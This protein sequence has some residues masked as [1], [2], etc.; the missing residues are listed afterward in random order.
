MTAN[1]LDLGLQLFIGGAWTTAPTF[2]EEGWTSRIGP[3]LEAGLQP[4]LFTCTIN[5]DTLAW[6]PSYKPGSNYGKFGRYTPTRAQIS[7]TTF[8]NGEA[9]SYSPERTKDHSPGAHRGRS[10]V[11][12]AFQG[13]QGRLN[14]WDDPLDSPMRRRNLSYGSDIRGYYPL[15]ETSNATNLTNLAAGGT[16]GTYSGT[17]SFGAEQSSGGSLP[18]V[19]IGSDGRLSG[20]F[21]TSTASGWQ[22][23]WTTKFD[24]APSSA[25]YET[26]MAWTDSL[27][28]EWHWDLNDTSFR[29]LVTDAGGTVLTN[30]FAL[31]GTLSVTQ[32]PI[33]FRIKVT[34]SAGTLQYEPAWHVQDNTFNTGFTSTFTAASTAS[35]R[36]WLVA[37]NAW[38]DG[39]AYGHVLTVDDSALDLLSVE[40]ISAFD[41]YYGETAG[42]RFARLMDENGLS[43]TILGTS[44][45]SALMGRQQPLK[46]LELLDEC[47]RTDD[48]LIYDDPD[49]ADELIFRLYGD[50]VNQTPALALTYGV[51]LADPFT[52]R[53]DDVGAVNDLT[54]TNWDGEETN[55]TVDTGPRSTLA[56]PNGDGRTRGSLAVSVYD[57]DDLDQ[58]GN[59]EVRNATLD[60]PRY[61]SVTF[62]LLRF[63]SYRTA[64]DAIRP[65]DIVTVDSAEV[66]QVLI[67]VLT[68]ERAGSKGVAETVTL[69]GTPGDLWQHGTYDSGRK[70]SSSKTVVLGGITSS[71]TSIVFRTQ[72]NTD[73]PGWSATNEPYNVECVE[74]GEVFTVTSM[75]AAAIGGT[76]D[77]EQTAT[78]TRGTNGFSKAI[79][80][81]Y[82][83]KIAASSRARWGKGRKA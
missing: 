12:F 74:T 78:I 82:H 9:S 72:I 66:D 25:T 43:Y 13:L 62:S 22:L 3:D 44:S 41:G 31:Y 54:V 17:V 36:S 50:L 32:Q 4:N 64:V 76:G 35:P 40:A 19:T 28:R 23:T 34:V 60:R 18:N 14:R 37:G 83:L 55:V 33:R 30:V 20:T 53:I 73:S 39:A 81:G 47:R 27:N 29:I 46:L 2:T 49:N 48:G 56:P 45:L 52:K 61:D 71:A 79:S 6:D 26:I 68:I 38:N 57:P 24:V 5:N 16:A 59:W 11:A 67:R 1:G 69:S 77:I 75:P 8:L 70:Y 58:R 42:A 80:N 21:R 65:G 51:E 63:P 7:G 15:E 10:S